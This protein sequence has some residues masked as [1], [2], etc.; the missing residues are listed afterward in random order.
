MKSVVLNI[1]CICFLLGFSGAGMAQSLVEAANFQTDASN[2]FIETIKVI[3]ASKRIFVITN[4]NQQLNPGDFISL[5]LDDQLAARAIVAKN[6]QGQVGIKIIRIYSMAQW[7]RFRR[8]LPVQII[9]GDDSR[10]GR[11]PTPTT[12]VAT[13]PRITSEEDLYTRDVV[14]D[15]DVGIFDENRNRHIK[16]D[17]LVAISATFLDLPA[18]D[19]VGGG[20]RRSNVFGVSWA[21]QF[22]DNFFLEGAYNRAMFNNYPGDGAQTLVN[23]YVVRLKFNVKAPLYSYVMPYVGYHMRSLVSPEAGLAPNQTPQQN[24]NEI[25]LI[26]DLQRSGPVFGVTLL[27]RLVPGWFIKADI[28]NDIMNVGFAVEF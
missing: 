24:Q 3:S 9:R 26:Q 1:F 17:N 5:A 27:R 10:F 28:G 8:E 20:T 22:T 2:V 4:S 6:H 21:F 18:L 13:G 12:D 19:Q 7:G 23:H 15:D 25:N 16:P 14:V 11:A